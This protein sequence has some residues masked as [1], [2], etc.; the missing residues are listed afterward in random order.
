MRLFFGGGSSPPSSRDISRGGLSEPPMYSSSSSE[1]A[2]AN[3][4][5][6]SESRASGKADGFWSRPTSGSDVSYEE[7]SYFF[8]LGECCWCCWLAG[9]TQSS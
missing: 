7:Y 5:C 4:T 6:C 8:A 1:N 3:A 9:A 2:D